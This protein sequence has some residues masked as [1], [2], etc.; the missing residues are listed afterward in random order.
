[1]V[2]I[3][4]GLG[5]W[6]LGVLLLVRTLGESYT[7]NT[8]ADT[9]NSRLASFGGAMYRWS[10]GTHRPRDMP[11]ARIKR[12]KPRRTAPINAEPYLSVI[13]CTRDDGY[14]D[15]NETSKARLGHA[16]HMFSCAEQLSDQDAC[17]TY[18]LSIRGLFGNTCRWS[19]RTRETLVSAS[20][21]T[22]AVPCPVCFLS[23]CCIRS[24]RPLQVQRTRNF[25]NSVAWLANASET[26]IELI[27]VDWNPPGP[28]ST[29]ERRFAPW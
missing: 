22:D 29:L 16:A 20:L 6:L 8:A 9:R 17:V 24:F 25:I 15:K 10:R 7:V 2:S 28:D 5:F 21:R 18:S 26:V 3:A 1:M 14:S 11:T 12:R 4:G 23:S 13:A 27:I 19:Q